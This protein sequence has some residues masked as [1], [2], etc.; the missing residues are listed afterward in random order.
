MWSLR[1]PRDAELAA[2]LAR[3]AGLAVTYPYVGMSLT[4]GAPGYRK[5]EHRAPLSIDLA[6]AAERLASFATHALPYLFVYPR[7]A[8]VVLRRDVVV[9]AKVGPVWSINPCRIVHV[10]STPDRFAYAYGT[11][12]GH[13]ESGEESFAVARTPGGVIGETIA[14]ARMAEWIA[15]LGA[16]IARRVQRTVKRDYLRALGA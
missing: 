13:A 1:R 6:T 11:L 9:C 8:R 12:P 4:G 15:K 14:Y 3:V 2:V 10:E 7:D 16:P 5:E